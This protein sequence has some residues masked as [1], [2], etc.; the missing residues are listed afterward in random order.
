MRYVILTVSFAFLLVVSTWTPHE[1]LI[2]QDA[3]PSDAAAQPET[4]P[5]KSV[6]LDNYKLEEWGARRYTM[7]G[8]PRKLRQDS[9]VIIAERQ[10]KR[11]GRVKLETL[12]SEDE[13]V[14][15]DSWGDPVQEMGWA[16]LRYVCKRDNLL[17][18][19]TMTYRQGGRESLCDVTDGNYEL[20]QFRKHRSGVWP[21]GTVTEASLIRIVTMLPRVKGIGYSIDSY[22][23]SPEFSPYSTK[24]DAIICHGPETLKINRMTMECTKY[25]F[26]DMQAWVRHSDNAL[27]RF[28]VPG[29]RELEISESPYE[30]AKIV[31]EAAEK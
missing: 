11:I 1:V 3:S 30:Y 27:V 21:E 16:D 15:E 8:F 10:R 22:S 29:W 24:G 28:L 23:P 26:R 17:T 6:P 12:V 5:L 13:V 14:F 19:K 20:Q 18:M 9:D 31:R 25:T 2:A 7:Y 4:Y